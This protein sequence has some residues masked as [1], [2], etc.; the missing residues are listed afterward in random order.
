L[1]PYEVRVM[2]AS[3]RQA[4]MFLSTASSSPERWRWPSLSNDWIPYPDIEP[5][6]TVFVGGVGDLAARAE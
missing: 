4:S 3:S 2:T 5:R 6:L 1:G